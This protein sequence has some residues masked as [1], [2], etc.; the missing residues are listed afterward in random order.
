A[1][2]ALVSFVAHPVSHLAEGYEHC[3]RELA[4]RLLYTSICAIPDPLVLRRAATPAVGRL[5]RALNE[6]NT[7]EVKNMQWETLVRLL[8]SHSS[9]LAVFS[10]TILIRVLERGLNSKWATVTKASGRV[11]A[12][13][14]PVVPAAAFSKL[15]SS[16]LTFITNNV[17]ADKPLI[18]A[19]GLTAL[20]QVLEAAVTR[21]PL[22]HAKTVS[23]ATLEASLADTCLFSVSDTLRTP[24][25]KCVGLLLS[26]ASKMEGGSGDNLVTLFSGA[27]SEA[28]LHGQTLALYHTLL[29]GD[30]SVI[31]QSA[32]MLTELGDIPAILVQRLQNTSSIVRQAASLAAGAYLAQDH[33][34]PSLFQALIGTLNSAE[35]DGSLVSAVCQGISCYCTALAGELRIQEAI[36]AVHCLN[37]LLFGR[38]PEMCFAS[39]QCLYDCL[40]L[41]QGTGIA[42]HIGGLGL[43]LSSKKSFDALL[44]EIKKRRAM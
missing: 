34:V 32:E 23:I 4:T 39:A 10:A 5:L 7:Y 1:A 8:E 3:T 30:L 9:S 19:S 41:K 35:M 42:D 40:A 37:P 15:V 26:A 17:A 14:A 21:L 25:A 11:L 24:A 18:A 22:S 33:P 2:R 16:V 36:V 29:D 43:K 20:G 38:Q 31:A 44:R 28:A 13:L 6:D 27:A 12:L